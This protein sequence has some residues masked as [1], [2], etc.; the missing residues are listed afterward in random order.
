MA[1]L[2]THKNLSLIYRFE[3]YDSHDNVLLMYA[4]STFHGWEQS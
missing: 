2:Y 4:L 1:L 3:L